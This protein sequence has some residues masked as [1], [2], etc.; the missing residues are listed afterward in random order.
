MPLLENGNHLRSQQIAGKHVM[1]RNTC[2]FDSVIQAL[3]VGFRDW[4]NY[5]YY[6]YINSNAKIN[7]ILNFKTTTVSMYGT[8]QKVYKERA[9]I[10][11]KIFQPK[12]G[13]VLR[14]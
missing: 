4:I 11:A 14:M 1:I 2:A 7:E 6:N 8:Q 3:L 5:I 13:E 12:K 10:L 9:L